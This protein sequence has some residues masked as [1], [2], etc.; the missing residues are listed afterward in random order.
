MKTKLNKT[1]HQLG[2]KAEYLPMSEEQI[3]TLT[4]L[5]F[6]ALYRESDLNEMP[7]SEKPFALKMIE[8]R[9]SALELPIQLFP[10]AKIA[11]LILTDGVPGK[12]N[13]ALIDLLIKHEN[14]DITV[15]E[16]CETY[17]I[18]FYSEKSC[19]EYIDNY[20]KTKK[21]KWSEIY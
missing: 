18:G 13:A 14:N 11:M 8:K 20:L 10:S 9:I 6:S 1:A 21:T 17:P 5:I 2:F 16:V 3:T 7:E 12:M 19:S 4:R 15:T